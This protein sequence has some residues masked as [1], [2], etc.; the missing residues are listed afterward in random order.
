MTLSSSGNC[1]DVETRK[2][3]RTVRLERLR[4]KNG[5]PMGGTITTSSTP[6]SKSLTNGDSETQNLHGVGYIAH[7]RRLI[8]NLGIY[9]LSQLAAPLATLILAPFLTRNLSHA[10]YGALAVLNTA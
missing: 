1:P 2:P 8:K 4:M 3:W 7:I 5:L 10:D 9:T 6:F